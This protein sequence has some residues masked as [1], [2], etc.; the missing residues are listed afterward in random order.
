MPPIHVLQVAKSSGGVGQYVRMIATGVDPRQVRLTV[1]C[2]SEGGEALAA[3]LN[4][5]PGVEAFSLPMARYRLDPIG[6]L[7]VGWALRQRIRRGGFD[8]IHAHASKPGFLARWAAAGSGVPVIY[9][10]HCFAFH[11]EA[12]PWMAW[13]WAGIERWAARRWTTTLLAVAEAE[14]RLGLARGV[15]RPEQYVV[16]HTGV[17]VE[18]FVVPLSQAEARQRLGLATDALWVGAV[19]RLSRQKDPLNLVQA[20]AQVRQRWPQ[21]RFVWVGE[22]PYRRRVL[23]AARALGVEEAFLLL[24]TRR[25]IPVVLRALD[26]FVLPSRWEAFPL[27]V[28][29]AMAAGLPVVAT[30]VGGV[31]EAVLAGE[32]GLLVPPARP[33]ALAQAIGRLVADPDLRRHLGHQGRLRVAWHFQRQPM[34]ARLFALYRQV[35]NAHPEPPQTGNLPEGVKR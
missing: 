12:A 34:L 28:L 23:R 7:R 6:D 27:T 15:G 11:A 17:D 24:G 22:G 33:D 25:D 8:L 9:S 13:L 32:T 20:A 4:A 16:L 18:R 35:V 14:R 19:G 21:V 30:A 26:L 29:E 10:P 1:A 31:G 5:L 2:L 3:E